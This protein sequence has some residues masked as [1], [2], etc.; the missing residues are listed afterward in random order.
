MILKASKKVYEVMTFYMEKCINTLYVEIKHMLK[1]FLLDEINGTK[2]ALFFF[3]ELQLITCY[4]IIDHHVIHIFYI[5]L[6]PIGSKATSDFHPILTTD[7]MQKCERKVKG[8]RF[9]V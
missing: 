2:N 7:S 4:I 6:L 1:K 8:K 3:H 5:F 9:S